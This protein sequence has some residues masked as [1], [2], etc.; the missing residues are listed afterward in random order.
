M[1]PLEQLLR[2]LNKVAAHRGNRDEFDIHVTCRPARNPPGLPEPVHFVI[3]V[4]ET[5][6][7][8]E[9]VCGGGSS[10]IEAG[11]D[12]LD[13]L[14]EDL[15]FYQYKIPPDVRKELSSRKGKE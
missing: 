8:H 7:G 1:E 5:E 11:N 13:V 10:L 3:T 14:L 6:D 12:V 2:I 4:V 15:K 9:I